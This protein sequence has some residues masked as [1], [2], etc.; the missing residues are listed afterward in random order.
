MSGQATRRIC[1]HRGAG[2]EAPSSAATRSSSS[3]AFPARRTR[4]RSSRSRWPSPRPCVLPI[5]CTPRP[6]SPRPPA[7]GIPALVLV[8]PPED[9]VLSLHSWSAHV[10]LEQALAAYSRFY[11]RIRPYR[12]WCTRGEFD[13][14]TTDLGA[15]TDDVNARY[16]TSFTRF[17]HTP[18]NVEACYRLIEEKSRR[19]AW[20]VAI[21]EYA[22]GAI[23]AAQLAAERAAADSGGVGAELSEVRVARPSAA[24]AA[25]R[26][27]ARA[28]STGRHGSRRPAAGPSGP[29]ASSSATDSGRGRPPRCRT[30]SRT[31]PS[32]RAAAA[33]AA[34]PGRSSR[35]RRSRSHTRSRRPPRRR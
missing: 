2:T 26:E 6:R 14:V 15:V 16:G 24:R 21:S 31:A 35:S 34:A 27:R 30:D 25:L 20:G 11:E 33:P 32:A 10:G 18:Q 5:T 3:R 19:P 13:Q 22:S 17:E 4:S 1:P 28:S 23:T 12:D 7:C 8:R 9:A 29:T